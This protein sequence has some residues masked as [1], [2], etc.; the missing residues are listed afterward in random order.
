MSKTNKIEELYSWLDAN[1]I[2]YERIDNEVTLLPGFGKTYFQ[3][4]QKSAYTSIFRKDKDGELVFNAVEE[5]DVLAREEIYYIVYKF[6][7]NFYYYDTREPFKLNILKYVGERV[8]PVR[9]ETYV[10][11]G[12]HTPYELLN[13]SFMPDMWVKKAQY[14][15]MTSLGIC[16]RNT[17]AA[18]F[19]FY[20]ACKAAGIR[21]VFGYSLTV[22]DGE[23][24]FDAKV[25]V[26][27]NEGYHNLLRIQKAIMVDNVELKTIPLREL[28]ARGRG[29]VLV[30]GKY[31]PA[32]MISHKDTVERLSDAFDGIYYQ[33][34]LTEYKAERIDI[35]VLEAA[36][37]YFDTC[38]DNLDMPAPVLI[39]DCY[40]LDKDDASN[41]IILNKIA[42]GAAHEQSDEQYFKDVDDQYEL[43][44]SLFSDEWDVD[45]LFKECCDSTV[46][47][48]DGAVA[49]YDLTRNYMPKYDMTPEEKAKYGTVH[50]MFTQLLEE[51]L[52]KYAPKGRE[53]EYRKRMEYEKYIIESTDNV[54]YLLY[55]YDTCNWARS[56][57]ILVG[58]GRG[59]AA[60]SLLLYLLGVTLIDPMKY[61]LIF[62]RFLLPERAG[63]YPTETTIIG[64]GMK[65]TDYV[66]IE[67]D[68][69]LSIRTDKRS[70]LIVKREGQEEPV[71]IC[72]DELQDGDDILFDNRDEIFTINE[73]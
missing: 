48:A 46:A 51:G 27:T 58:C 43:F 63:L 49:D 24:Q 71:K 60:G 50:H 37:L 39:S 69:G 73:L 33:V 64:K 56:H 44:K 23:E 52:K 25:Y 5:P 70:Q 55:Q 54:D 38:Y 14:L 59:S 3:D 68:N 57:N 2:R 9:Q 29:N 31:T 21:H 61:D 8:K 36:K 40:Y 7:N 45:E 22:D 19:G 15:G 66:E 42:T 10:N 4:T 32:Y 65:S 12:I 17:M 11:L 26:Q 13:G 1:K 53:E 67:L 47:I 62:E 20:K 28:L 41:K 30:M 6:G 18:C 34:D 35:K 72:A 16:D